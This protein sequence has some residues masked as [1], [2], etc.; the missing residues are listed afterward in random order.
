MTHEWGLMDKL[1]EDVRVLDL[2]HV[3]FGP[4]TTL[5]LAEMGAEVIKIEPPWGSL[6]RLSQWGPMYG[7]AS[8]TFHHLNL[9]KKDIAMNLK[10][11]R[12]KKIF[13]DLVKISDVVITNFIPGT[14]ERLGIGYDDLKKIK[15]DIIYA[16]LSGFGE[17]GPYNKRASYAMIAEAFAGFSRQQG[18]NVDPEG[19]PY[20]MTGAFGDLAPGTMA[21]MAII[22]ALRYRDK[23]GVGQ[24]I[25]VA[26]LDT[27]FAY[28]VNITN[29]FVSGKDEK[30]RREEMAPM[31]KAREQTSIGGIHPVKDGHIYLMGFRAKGMDALKEK[32]GV[33]E[34]TKDMVLDYIKDMTKA[35]ADTF[36]AGV[37]L[38]V[39]PINFASEST[40]DPQ[41]LARDMVIELEHPLLGKYKAVNF[42]VKFSE[43]PGEVHSPAPLL[44]QHNREILTE[45]L[46]LS[47]E[48]ITALEKDGVIAKA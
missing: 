2:T 19:P 15:S 36:F 9:N 14:M 20:T 10:D 23:T 26:Q 3:W 30:T 39:A 40:V 35:E 1:L 37:G 17:T 47:E 27:M 16:A 18:D 8:P 46:G 13:E 34:V 41:V 42:P 12:I 33:E 44:G 45:L 7:G 11:P 32:L 5:M 21:A 24:K 6:G 25:D 22:A 31:R 48:E 38:P 4:W 43:T 29:Y 28:N